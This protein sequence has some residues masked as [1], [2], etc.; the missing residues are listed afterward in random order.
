MSE[1]SDHMAGDGDKPVDETQP[2]VMELPV[3]AA[4]QISGEDDEAQECEAQECEAQEYR[5]H[6]EAADG[7]SDET[8]DE[9]NE[10][11]SAV[12]VQTAP[13][14]SRRF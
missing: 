3:V 7:A 12:Q 1:S 9:P 6:R 5:A 2:I 11:A 10:A 4:P 8:K 13:V 14:Q